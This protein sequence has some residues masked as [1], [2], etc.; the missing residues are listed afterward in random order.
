MA[1]DFGGGVLQTHGV[2][3]PTIMSLHALSCSMGCLRQ[4]V[5]SRVRKTSCGKGEWCAVLLYIPLCLELKTGLVQCDTLELFT[6][7]TRTSL[8]HTHTHSPTLL[9]IFFTTETCAIAVS[10]CVN[11]HRIKGIAVKPSL[12]YSKAAKVHCGRHVTDVTLRSQQFTQ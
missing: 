4:I 5:I 1:N 7:Y 8:S 3:F 9:C 11:I 10:S 12:H 2:L 6:M